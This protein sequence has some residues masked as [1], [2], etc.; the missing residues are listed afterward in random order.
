MNKIARLHN[1]KAFNLKK[2]IIKKK[3]QFKF[4][5]F[6]L[7]SQIFHKNFHGILQRF[8]IH[9][10]YC[11]F[12][13]IIFISLSET[14]PKKWDQRELGNVNKR[15]MFFISDFIKCLKVVLNSRLSAFNVCDFSFFYK[16]FLSGF[17]NV[18]LGS[19]ERRMIWR[20]NNASLLN[21]IAQLHQALNSGCIWI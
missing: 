16:C 3:L 14:L 15:K 20:L 21:S 19:M 7:F 9:L 2:K 6:I 11:L 5:F 1:C 18:F 17:R 12:F 4:K 10:V 13:L 8:S